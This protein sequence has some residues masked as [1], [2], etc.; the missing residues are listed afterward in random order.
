MFWIILIIL[1]TLILL[2]LIS[3]IIQ[4]LNNTRNNLDGANYNPEIFS[5]KKGFP[6]RD[7]HKQIQPKDLDSTI[8]QPLNNDLIKAKVA[9]L[10]LP[11]WLT[12]EMQA[13]C[14]CNDCKKLRSKLGV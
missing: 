2:I 10:Q 4:K 14:T 5:P 3:K 9:N 13:K 12:G 11:C 8:W 6:I 1:V 7:R